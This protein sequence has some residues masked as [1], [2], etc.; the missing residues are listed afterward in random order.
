M[1]NVYT[2]LSAKKRRNPGWLI[3]FARCIGKTRRL[4]IN[5]RFYRSL[6]YT[7][8]EALD[9]AQNTVESMSRF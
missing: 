7:P 5:Y 8:R 1:I 3:R 9:K 2:L 4:I 6:N